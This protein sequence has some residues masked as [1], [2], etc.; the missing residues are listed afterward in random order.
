[1]RGGAGR[2]ASGG[3]SH[4]KLSHTQRDLLSMFTSVSKDLYGTQVFFIE[5]RLCCS[6]VGNSLKRICNKHGSLAN[7][8]PESLQLLGTTII[9]WTD[10][11]ADSMHLQTKQTSESLLTIQVKDDLVFL[12]ILSYSTFARLSVLLFSNKVGMPTTIVP[13]TVLGLSGPKQEDVRGCSTTV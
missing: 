2:E 12:V 4:C 7:A 1:L 11:L 9:Y 3:S 5:R 13:R 6:S 8:F 10:R